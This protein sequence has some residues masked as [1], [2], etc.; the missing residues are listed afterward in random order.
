MINVLLILVFSFWLVLSIF[1]HFVPL[2]KKKWYSVL[3]IF[4]LIPKWHFFAPHPGIDDYVLLFQYEFANGTQSIWKEYS[5]KN[6]IFIPFLFHP[7]RRIQK[8]LFDLISQLDTVFFKEHEADFQI[9]LNYILFLNLSVA[10]APKESVK[11]RFMLGSI[12][13]N[14]E[15]KF[16]VIALSN[17]HSL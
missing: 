1:S 11:S 16:K 3:E 4:G 15:E 14:D 2:E 8:C 6:K 13:Q 12:R 9:S 17:F 10:A 7:K 5:I